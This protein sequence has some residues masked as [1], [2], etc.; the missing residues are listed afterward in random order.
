[1]GSTPVTLM[2]TDLVNST[3]LLQRA[4][5][6]EAQRVFRSHHGL[7]RDAVATYAGQEV[8]WLGD[9]LMAVFPSA[10]D[11]V[12]C[13]VAMQQAARRRAAGE[14]LGL[15]VGLHVG[16]ALADEADYVGTPVVVARRLC[17][18]ATAGQI[19]CSQLVV[20]LLH[21]RQAFR[22]DALGPLE[23]KGLREPVGAHAVAYARDDLSAALRHTPFTG[24]ADELTRLAA[25]LEEARAGSGGVV[26]L[27]GEPGI[28]KTRTLE[29]F[30][31]RARA[32]AALVLSGRCYEAEAG[33]PYGP[34]AEAIAACARETP[35]DILRAD[36]GLGAAPLARLVPALREQLPDIP[37][38]VPLQ[39]DE[40]RVRLLDAVTQY[41]L[42]VAARVPTVLV[43]DDL[44]WADPGTVMLLRHVARFAARARLLVLGAYRDVE[45]ESQDPLTELLGTLPRE[46]SHDRLALTGLGEPAVHELLETLANQKV[47]R[48]F[49][50]A[51]TRETSGNPFF[52]RAALLHLLEDG[53]LGQESGWG[54]GTSPVDRIGLPETVRKVIERRLRRLSA[55]A[56]G[57]LRVAAA[58]TGGIDFEVAH[59]VAGLEEAPALDALDEALDA[60]LLVPARD[61]PAY[62]FTHAL[63]RQTLRAALNPSRQTRLHR[64]IADAYCE[65]LGPRAPAADVARQYHLSRSLPGAERGASYAISAAESALS[66][67]AYDSAASLLRLALDL[68]RLDDPTRARLLGRLG[69]ALVWALDFGAAE[70]VVAEA[71]GAIAASEGNDQAADFVAETVRA[72]YEAG[73]DD[74]VIKLARIGLGFAGQRRDE[75]WATLKAFD[76]VGREAEDAA[77]PGLPRD[78]PERR[79][80]ARIL[81]VQSGFVL[82]QLSVRYFTSRD[83]LLTWPDPHLIFEV[84]DYRGGLGPLRTLAMTCESHG[85]I[86]QAVRYWTRVAR[87]QTA[88]GLLAESRQ[89][90]DRS[91]ALVRRLPGPSS[92]AAQIL[93]AEDEWRM[94]MDAGLDD[95]IGLPGGRPAEGF[96]VARNRAAFA[97]SVARIHARMGRVERARRRL[98]DLIPALEHAPPWAENYTR[99]ACDAA[100][101]L[102]FSE[103][104]DFADVIERSVRE[105]VVEPDFRYPMMDGRLALA[106]LCALQRRYEEAVDWFTRARTVLDEQCAR[107]LRAIVDHDEA[108]MYLR[109]RAPGDQDRAKPLLDTALAQFRALDMPGW[110]WRAEALLAAIDDGAAPIAAGNTRPTALQGTFR[111]QGPV[112]T[113]G[114][115]GQTLGLPHMRGLA[116]L[117]QLLLHPGREFHVRTL[118]SLESGA[119]LAPAERAGAGVSVVTGLGDAGEV[120]DDEAR[121]AYRERLAE[122]RAELEEAEGYHDI[123]RADR[124]RGELEA[125]EQ[126]L[127]SAIGLGGRSRRARSDID[128]RRVAVTKRIRAAIAQIVKACPVLGDHLTAS[129]RTGVHCIY[130]PPPEERVEWMA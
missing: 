43:L 108:L 118:D 75:T 14:R 56:L 29:E 39:P 79:E 73:V 33:R 59:R 114:Y 61:P 104:T 72:Q 86:A 120:L 124:L 87:Y 107:P 119:P 49:A 40:E 23:L 42:A 126:E 36:L 34:F 92:H 66:T 22:F 121:R 16:E 55:P 9:G 112:W 12:R 45:V 71:A 109:R 4:G 68:L 115:G 128:R 95:P 116:D 90:I 8:K 127:G 113:I 28:G 2:F 111:R 60:Q 62:D 97:A 70:Q 48:E 58:F 10:A 5:D 31:E 35:P 106:R 123:G 99:V 27:A 25:R 76:L 46:T 51:L 57:L 81:S 98:G 69:L 11:A 20:E 122:V 130:D 93:V 67:Y 32:Q 53:A 96:Y 65:V 88:L 82:P 78:F 84:A 80:V 21:G 64:A 52:I 44:H 24:R 37:E 94:A 18:R 38:P 6:E 63:V 105:K 85:R 100:E 3:E 54:Q 110:I 50:A 91:I 1:M 102:W 26:L 30:A 7:L 83:E 89:S 117:Q 74:R 47:S 129:V 125:L 101:T 19:V 15:R 17:D 77:E 103:C 13:A 41:L